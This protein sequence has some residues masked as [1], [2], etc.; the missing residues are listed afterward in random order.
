MALCDLRALSA[1]RLRSTGVINGVPVPWSLMPP[2]PVEVVPLAVAIGAQVRMAHEAWKLNTNGVFPRGH[3]QIQFELPPPVGRTALRVYGDLRTNQPIIVWPGKYTWKSTPP[4]DRI[5]AERLRNYFAF[6]STKAEQAQW[7]AWTPERTKVQWAYF[8]DERTR[9]FPATL[10]QAPAAPVP[11]DSNEA[12]AAREAL[13]ADMLLG[14]H[15][16]AP[17]GA[18]LVG[19]SGADRLLPLPM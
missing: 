12:R 8:I 16:K 11:R 6:Q 13:A 3:I 17:T 5:I 9:V 10:P 1:A 18:R 4:G 15:G 2:L 14:L 19:G 7:A